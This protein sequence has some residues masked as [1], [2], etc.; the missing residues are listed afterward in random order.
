[1]G[2]GG[3]TTLATIVQLD[4]I[5]V[6]FSISD[7]DAMRLR[8]QARARGLTRKDIASVP[9]EIDAGT[10]DSFSIKGRLDYASPETSTE[11]GTVTVR[12]VFDNADR[13]LLPGL[14][15]RLR[16]PVE[17]IENAL[18]VPPSAIGTDQEGRYV[19]VVTE[20]GAVERRAVTLTER[21]GALQ[22][23]TGKI[24]ASDWVV[25]NVLSGPRPG[26]SVTRR[27]VPSPSAVLAKTAKA[28]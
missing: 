18:L 9:V 17:T 20:A 12:A 11:T 22:Q 23:V 7:A 16:I 24:S 25:Q 6:A 10:G 8:K 26:E 27:E 28:R 15:V 3:V 5:H 14:T 21:D 13:A 4:P 1:M 19:L 2:S